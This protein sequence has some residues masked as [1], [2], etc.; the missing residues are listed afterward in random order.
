M[1]DS[2]Y[3][4]KGYGKTAL[5]LGIDYLLNH[6]DVREV[7]T[8]YEINNFVAKNLYDSVGFRETGEVVGNDVGMKLIIDDISDNV[9]DYM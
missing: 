6:F 2:N 7:Y 9:P 1:I 5:K 3:Q 4:N 8:A